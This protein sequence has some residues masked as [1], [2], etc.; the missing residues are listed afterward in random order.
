MQ[1]E[2]KEARAALPRFFTLE[3][4]MFT[5]T[6]L[7]GLVLVWNIIVPNRNLAVLFCAGAVFT[8]SIVVV[9]RLLMDPDSVRA[10][11]SD[12][13]LK[14]ASQTL[15]CMSEGLDSEAAQKICSLLLPSTAAIA[16]AITDKD[17]I[18]G[19]A[20]FEEAQNPAGSHIRTHATHATI[21]D[22]K[23]RILFTPEDIGFPRESSNIKAAIIVPL[24]VGRT[25]SGTLKFYY[26][27][28]N[29]I[30]ETQK[31]IAEGFG[32]L[33]STQ[34]AASAL[35][36]QTKLATSMELKM[37]QSQ[38]NPHFLFNTINTI[39]SLI[40]TDPETARKLLREFAVFYR[41]TL[42]DSA[43]LILFA[44]EM[45]QTKR[46]FT[47]EVARFGPDR[48]AMKVDI[49]PRVDDMLI[50]PFLI[51]PLVENAVRHA[52][53]S[54]G[55]LTISVTGEVEG[56]N[57]VIR[58]TDDGVGM[59][60]EAR[61]N[62]LHPESSSGLGIAVKNVHDRI[63]GYFGPGTCM[64]VESELGRGT[65]VKLMLVGGAHREYQ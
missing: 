42:E 46:Y 25:V 15:A 33:L 39:A 10:R 63:R 27:R 31:S 9:I 16:V 52:M 57:V 47:F 49:D 23:M 4:F 53:P 64:D 59:T 43:D 40:R 26:R 13:M 56:N 5:V 1:E 44:R 28:A 14:L 45:E 38:I 55:K 48:V 22:G 30:S 3:M 35:E 29:H 8:L 19:Y 41:R 24:F 62:I 54:E 37:L 60:E 7:S 12:A 65:S 61:T 32:Q 34:M 20:G 50:P 17:Q 58:V 11:Q 36:E 18:L 51:Q 2:R 21:A 6:A